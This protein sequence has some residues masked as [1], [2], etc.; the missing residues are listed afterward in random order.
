MSVEGTCTQGWLDSSSSLSSM[1]SRVLTASASC[2]RHTTPQPLRLICTVPEH[3]VHCKVP[4]LKLHGL[5]HH[6]VRPIKKCVQTEAHPISL[7]G[8]RLLISF[9]GRVCQAA[10]ISS[11]SLQVNA[12]SLTQP[13]IHKSMR[14]QQSHLERF[15]A[16][17]CWWCASIS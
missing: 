17:D 4:T 2:L 8:N 13:G 7:A 5:R 12:T 6:R 10:V 14:M 11:L 15:K 1:L 16:A 9:A 3:L